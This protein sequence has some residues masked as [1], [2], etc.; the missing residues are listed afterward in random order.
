MVISG[1][2]SR[3]DHMTIPHVIERDAG[4]RH[5]NGKADCQAV[6]NICPRRDRRDACRE[7]DHERRVR[8]SAPPSESVNI[9]VSDPFPAT[10]DKQGTSTENKG[11]PFGLVVD[12][13]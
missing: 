5:R 10:V 6:V 3:T 12:F 7:Q 8:V 13:D 9:T 4:A 11:F 2:G 1:P